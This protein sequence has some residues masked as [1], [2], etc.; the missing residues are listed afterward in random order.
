MWNMSIELKET[1]KLL[2][3][4][5]KEPKVTLDVADEMKAKIFDLIEKGQKRFLV[6]FKGVELIDSAGLGVLINTGQKLQLMPEGSLSFCNVSPPLM[7]IFEIVNLKQFFS[8]YEDEKTAIDTIVS[9]ELNQKKILFVGTNDEDFKKLKK[10]CGQQAILERATQLAE[11]AADAYIIEEPFYK[12]EMLG[13]KPVVILANGPLS[14]AQ[15][16]ALKQN[17]QAIH[18]AE[19]PFGDNEAKVLLSELI[20]FQS[21]K[22]TDNASKL[23][24]QLFEHYT[25]SL[26]EKLQTL[27]DLIQAA[28]DHPSQESIER[29]KASLHKISGS[30]GTYG[31]VKAGEICKQLEQKLE[32]NLQINKFDEALFK[33]IHDLF[34]QIKFYFNI[35]FYKDISKRNTAV[36][37]TQSKSVFL[38]STDRSVINMF[39]TLAG[40][41]GLRMEFETDPER[42]IQHLKDLDFKPELIVVE[43][44]FN[45]QTIDGLDLIKTIK[46]SLL[47]TGIKFALLIEKENFEINMRAA[48]DGIRFI[49]KKP[50]A[51][52]DINAIFKCLNATQITKPYKV[53]VVDDDIDICNFIKSAIDNEN[54]QIQTTT[55]EQKILEHLY[56]F[57]PNLL[58]LDINLK[59]YD[60]WSVLSALRKDLRYQTLKTIVITST[61]DPQALK[62]MHSDCDDVWVKPL[63]KLQLQNQILSFAEA[64]SATLTDTKLTSFKSESD[65]KKLL[66]T[67]TSIG[68]K[69]AHPFMLAVFGAREYT[70]IVQSGRGAEEEYLIHSE[71]LFD[72]LI[73]GD[74][75]R[76]YLEKGRFAFLFCEAN[77]EE[78]KLAMERT[79][80]DMDFKIM[81]KGRSEDI[82]ITFAEVSEVF[83]PGSIG[84]DELIGKVLQEFDKKAEVHF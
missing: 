50:I 24:Q 68:K 5:I 29:L 16:N 73:K 38:V 53:L 80:K 17:N 77:M 45:N 70:E 19:R 20:H 26:P 10:N 9:K 40:E 62:R 78:V 15:I 59:S 4:I 84:V 48:I 18:I 52:K 60:G 25:Q 42:V 36:R 71:N 6:N 35:T 64:N 1:G 76:G 51:H 47:A 74:S 37:P 82:F 34:R 55:D 41:L 66:L 8:I 67:L 14:V 69:Q 27:E 13:D 44:H 46:N 81:V 83:I 57:R 7:D 28:A 21:I 54:I 65:F 23:S 63:D 75:L 72:S 30:A 3:V 32:V 31:Y 79:V 61:S 49:I 56:E 43:S 22:S 12:K 33:V 39:N 2:I 11:N 58:L